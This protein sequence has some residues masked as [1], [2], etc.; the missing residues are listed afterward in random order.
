MAIKEK[1]IKKL[2]GLAAGHCSYPGCD[3]ECVAFLSESSTVIGEMAHVISKKPSGPRGE[4]GHGDDSYDNLILL[5]PTHH[6]IIDKA[7]EEEYPPGLLNQWKAEHE[8]RVRESFSVPHFEDKKSLCVAIK[9]LLVENYQ[10]WK[11]YGPDSEQANNNPLSNLYKIWELRK[12]SV[13][14]P[15]N[16]RIINLIRSHSKYFSI[17]EYKCCC[18]FIEHVEGFEANAYSRKEGVPKFPL[19]FEEVVNKY[20]EA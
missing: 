10:I 16:R 17:E 5:C 7:P 9:R 15:N 4:F 18:K 20:G 13:I 14:I 12:L 3:T 11:T 19:E 2:W 6:A 1:D 8:N